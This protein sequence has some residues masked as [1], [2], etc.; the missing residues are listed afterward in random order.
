MFGIAYTKFSKQ[1]RPDEQWGYNLEE[2]DGL[3]LNNRHK[4]TTSNQS[5]NIQAVLHLANSQ[6]PYNYVNVSL[7]TASQVC[8]AF[9]NATITHIL[10]LEWDEVL[11]GSFCVY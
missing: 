9:T 6:L 1:Y 11:C 2:V 7:V 8:H 4:K 10:A 5:S 3:V